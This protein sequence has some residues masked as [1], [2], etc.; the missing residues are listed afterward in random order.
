M[1]Y[2]SVF[3][4]SLLFAGLFPLLAAPLEIT[5]KAPPPAGAG[6]FEFGADKNPNGDEISVNSRS[7]LLNGQPWF[8]VMGEFQNSRVPESEWRDELLKMK[9]GGVDIVSTYVFWIHQ[10]EVEGQ[11]DWTGR[12][13]LRKFVQTC[14]DV[15]LKV[16]VRCGPWCHGEVRNG[17]LPD[18]VVAH[19]DWKSRSTDTNF[20]AAVK[21]L[22]SQIADQ[23]H[24]ELW[25]DGGPVIGIQL[26]N[27]FGGSPKYLLA[28]KQ[29]AIESGLDVPLYTKTGWPAM[30]TPVP[31]G[32]LLPLFGT[33]P[34]GFWERKLTPMNGDAWESFAFKITRTDT[35]VGDD[36]LGNRASGDTAGT[37]KYPY[38]TCEIGGGMPASYHRR[39]NYDPR[40]VEAVALCQLGSGSSLMG[41]Y[42]Y[43]GGQNPDGKLTTLQES[44]ATGYP[45]DL[46][47]KTYDFNAPLGE[48]GQVNPQ[49]SWLRRLHLFLHDFGPSL[50][51]MPTTLPASRPVNKDDVDTLRW[52]VRSDGSG[53][54]VFVNNYQRLQPMPAKTNVQFGLNLSRGSLVFPSRPVT[55]PAGEFFFWPFNINLGG[56]RLVYATA[57]PICQ[58]QSR[59]VRTVFFAQ[60]PG[61]E[62][63][64]AFDG[65]EWPEGSIDA[66][67]GQLGAENG[68]V[69]DRN[70]KPS[71][72]GAMVLQYPNGTY[73]GIVLLNEADSLKLLKG[74]FGGY[75][76]VFLSPAGLAVNG[77][78]MK[79]SSDNPTNLTVKAFPKSA[80]F[81]GTPDGV[82]H[83]LN[84]AVV[85]PVSMKVKFRSLRPAGPLREIPINAK[86]HLAVAP[87]DSDFTNA[88]IWKIKLPSKIDLSLNPILRIHY[89]GDVARLTLNGKLL[90]DNFYSGR[91]FDLGLKR[92]APD[93]LTGNLQL[94]ILPLVKDAPIYLEPGAKPDFGK[95]GSVAKVDSVEI[96]ND[97]N[98]V[99]SSD[100]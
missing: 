90:D 22:Y 66:M 79:L 21:V 24:G 35:G 77:D 84:L 29:I 28:L 47:E 82:F 98:V 76:Y 26:D 48:Y 46:P 37:E 51:Q 17:G 92:Y 38:L 78:T 60:T 64:F 15:G 96:V 34:D 27:E 55:I 6:Y 9:A 67:S 65:S 13:D 62:A 33:Y 10:E 7:L 19:K 93:I 1:K 99:V 3:L 81:S 68:L 53:G 30:R 45:N 97:Y 86:T 2:V 85:K 12:R 69:I 80:K 56:A 41:Y 70:V 14:N 23:L 39:M 57:Q 89:V 95:A 71:R 73:L 88:A 44:Q 54:Y 50:A 5:I 31:L 72:A 20:L 100:R 74:N 87:I 42:M 52:A 11:W 61:V 94:E 83:G 18:W 4:S 91:T 16:I 32:Q 36:E 8:P 63:E 49:Y 59:N 75:E 43:H 58:I 25:K 40:D